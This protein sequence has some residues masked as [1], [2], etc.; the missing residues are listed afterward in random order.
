MRK[1]WDENNLNAP[2][3]A[4]IAENIGIQMI[5]IHGRTRNQMFKESRIGS[6]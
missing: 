6:L 3:L 1:G 2:Q 4:K 5:T